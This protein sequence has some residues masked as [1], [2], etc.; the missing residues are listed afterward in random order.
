VN[1][2]AS[3]ARPPRLASWLASLFALDNQAEP[4]EGDLLEEFSAIASR[5]N[6]AAAR[7]WY[8]KQSLK[9]SAHLFWTSLRTAPGL[10]AATTI[11]AFFFLWATQWLPVRLVFGVLEHYSGFFDAH[12]DGWWFCVHYGG[13]IV[14]W[15][16]A[17][18]LGC[19]I[20]V[21]ARGREIVATAAFGVFR[22]VGAPIPT[23]ALFWTCRAILPHHLLQLMSW[24]TSYIGVV[25]V[26]GI[27]FAEA[28]RQGYGRIG[29][30]FLY[31]IQPFASVLPPILGGL[32]VRR[33]RQSASRVPVAA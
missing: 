11:G 13:A 18:L 3:P 21:V 1:W 25:V 28:Y 19:L 24:N 9:T 23:I 33:I 29:L 7:R 5:A 30:L 17:I 12:F 10:I 20:G 15:I 16:V 14:G 32:L 27:N 6:P 31:Y 26:R 22:I 8:W 4:I 2:P